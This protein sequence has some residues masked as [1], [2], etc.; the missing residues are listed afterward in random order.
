MSIKT[1]GKAVQSNSAGLQK[2]INKSAEKLVFDVLQS[3]QY[4]TP[5]AS[6]VR[7]LVTNAC[8]SQR[9]K[10]I[11]LEILSGKKKVEDYYITRHEEEYKDSNFDRTYYDSE[12]LS[13]S[14]NRVTV[15]Y[16]ENDG[17][18][19][20]DVFSVI[21]HG[22]GIG[23][24]RLEGYLE[25]GF[26]TKR[27]TAE[28]F[29][30]FGLGA[31]VPLSTGV[32]FY[33]VET[34]HNG[35]LFKM[36]C[37]AY[38]TDFL[39]GKFQA[40]GHITFS[41]GTQVNY[42]NTNQPNFT[43][44]SFGVKRHNRTKFVDA[45]QDQLNYID[46]VDMKYVYEDGTEM[47]RSVRSDVLYN[48]DNLIISDTWAWRRPH[49]VMVK[50]PGATTGINYGFVDFRELE[51]EQL[52]G[53]VGIKCP[54][55][56]AYVDDEGNEI[57]IQDGVEVTPSREKVIWNEHTKKYI[58]G[59]I[60]R[61]AQDAANVISEQLDEDDFLTWVKK[62]SE[63]IYKNTGN[64]SVLRQLGEM[65]DKENVKPKFR[66]GI[67]FAAPG[68]IL[69]GYKV[70]NVS[71]V[72]KDGKYQIQREEV[73]WGQV[74]WDNLY[75]VKGNPSARKD[76]YLSQQDRG[77]LTL[78][79][80][81]H[82]TN[83][84]NDDKV[85][86]K[87]DS[88][89]LHMASNWELIKDCPL[90]KFDY[91]E[92]EVPADFDEAIEKQLEQEGLKNRY[93]FMTPEERRSLANEVVLY[94][95][96][97]PYAGDKRWCNSIS[98]WT[99]DKVEAPLQLIQ[100][101]DIETYYGTS[102]D[103]AMLQLAATICAPTVPS[104]QDV[105]PKLPM[106]HPFSNTDTQMANENPVFTEFRPVRLRNDYN[107]QWMRETDEEPAKVT[108]IQLFKVSGALSK[109]MV[110]DNIKH[111]SEFFSVLHENKWSMHKK[112]RE[113]ATGCMLPHVPN[114]FEK[115]KEV[116]PKYKDVL[117]KLRP[118]DKYRHHSR[119]WSHN[120]D[121]F[122]EIIDLMKKMHQL[123]TFM[124]DDHDDES[125]A[126]K[127]MELFKVADADCTIADADIHALGQYLDEFL[128]P[129]YPLF[130]RINFPYRSDNDDKFWKEIRAYLE[131]KDRHNFEPP[132]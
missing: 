74:N 77:T 103:E 11:A 61:A 86:M 118:Y 125:V 84:M 35:K 51:M 28:N 25:L 18:G 17:T 73:G 80:E 5:I 126:Q 113:W 58:Q 68:G 70:R 128:E 79:T 87:I 63:V 21:D 43:K 12:Y 93:R 47:D 20:C 85:Q 120:E 92:I 66:T 15:R 78:I 115:L 72:W 54:A 50:S 19:Y 27:N 64:D 52:W 108:D 117:D 119:Y 106:F 83:L 8:D 95:L 82:M 23:E 49:I 59:A 62:C 131:L 100:D 112:V 34:A 22:V 107:G 41:D 96:R 2:R 130:E 129:L 105:Y 44:I 132:L 13:D 98:D 111:I 3:S 75:F 65:V 67:T 94:T 9:E 10:E 104:W 6:T 37:F 99:W 31:K 45:V 110:G 76:L 4:S 127:S 7:E 57:V 109:K 71:R 55:R 97:R 38:K 36:N 123:Q 102:E 39:V 114:W 122:K 60:E 1:I 40:D 88:I 24:S 124:L 89:N 48:S 56:Q 30:A 53:A 16:K 91:D 32:D 26:S 46:N 81:H 14:N 69:K 33:T 29:G 121:E 90:L 101:T 42:I 116:D